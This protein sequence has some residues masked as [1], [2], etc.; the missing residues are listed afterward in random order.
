MMPLKFPYGDEA[1]LVLE[2]R[3]V[4]KVGTIP[5]IEAGGGSSLD[6]A[7]RLLIGV[8]SDPTRMPGRSLPPVVVVILDGEP[9][10]DWE[11]ALSAF[12][13]TE[14]GRRALTLCLALG[15]DVDYKILRMIGNEAVLPL[16]NPEDL[17]SV[18]KFVRWASTAVISAAA[19]GS[20]GGE[21]VVP[22]LPTQKDGEVW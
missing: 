18:T 22:P 17:L 3:P 10:D 13:E 20:K 15:E 14:W 2:M 16:R 5:E 1:L 11:S 4:E 19:A 6:A 21:L 7:L 9:T 12:R 8:F